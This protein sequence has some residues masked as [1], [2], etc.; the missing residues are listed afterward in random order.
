LDVLGSRP[1]LQ[2]SQP[3]THAKSF[4]VLAI[5]VD[6]Q[7]QGTGLGKR[8]MVEV[9]SIA[10]KRGFARLHLTVEVDNSRAIAFYQNLGWTKLPASDGAW[11]GQMVKSLAGNFE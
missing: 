1:V 2:L 4:G 7:H 8:L 11:R 9:E 5:A 10:A 3:A 6:P